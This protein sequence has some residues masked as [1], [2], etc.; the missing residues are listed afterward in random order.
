MNW[1][2]YA[3]CALLVTLLFW[4]ID[5]WKNKYKQEVSEH[6]LTTVALDDAVEK[7]NGWK[8]A[9][10]QTLAASEGYREAGQACLDREEEARAALQERKDILQAAPPRERTQTEKEQ[11]VGD[12]TRIRAADRLNR[13]L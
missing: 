8:K 13:P 2:P 12:E 6:K 7:G 9:Y 1:K 3:A 10:E 11:V 4:R 5:H